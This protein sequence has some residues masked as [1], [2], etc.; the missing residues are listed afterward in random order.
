MGIYDVTG[1]CTVDKGE[2]GETNGR[3]DLMQPAVSG[4]ALDAIGFTEE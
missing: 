1:K 3:I 2:A 4:D